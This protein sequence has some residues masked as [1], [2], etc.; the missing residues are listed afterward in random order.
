M[1]SL[2]ASSRFE[3][4]VSVASEGRVKA[5]GLGRKAR[6]SSESASERERLR[7]EE[8]RRVWRVGRCGR[9]DHAASVVGAENWVGRASLG[10]MTDCGRGAC[11]GIV[12]K[13]VG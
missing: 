5:L 3:D 7:D 6:P 13:V 1:P 12:A 10:V 11:S 4:V 8:E 2:D 9:R